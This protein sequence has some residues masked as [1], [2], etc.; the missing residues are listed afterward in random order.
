MQTGTLRL[1]VAC[2]SWPLARSAVAS[3]LQKRKTLLQL[4]RLW[5]QPH[6]KKDAG[7]CTVERLESMTAEAAEMDN[8]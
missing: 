7:A 3:V 6:D 8:V 5:R 1:P 4:R 2:V